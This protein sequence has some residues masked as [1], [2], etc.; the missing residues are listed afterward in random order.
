M[1]EALQVRFCSAL[2]SLGAPAEFG[3]VQWARDEGRHGG[4]HR[5]TA[6]DTSVFDRASINVSQ[7]HYDDLPAKKLSSATALSTIIHPAHPHAPSVHMHLSFTELRDSR[8]GWRLM[9]DLNPSIPHAEDTAAFERA[10]AD[11]AAEHLEAGKAQGDRYF[12]IPAL[13][14]HRGV[15]HF[16]IEGYRTKS[17]AADLEF[18]RRFGAT[19]IDG[20]VEVLRARLE[21]SEVPSEEERM[22][23]LGYHT[24]YFFQ[25]LTLD[26]GTTSGILVHD[27]NDSGILGSLPSHVDRT[28]LERWRSE[29]PQLQRPLMDGL[30]AALP[31]DRIA[32]VDDAVKPALAKVVREHY[33]AF[34]DALALQAS[35]DIVPPTVANHGDA[36]DDR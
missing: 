32:A 2:E 28:L 26:R 15:S 31:D 24:V 17:D 9:A 4:G 27:Q 12:Y 25:V 23:A 36:S 16:Y 14:R 29:L 19:M 22:A 3:R 8:G 11:A 20:Y 18:A 1:V 30:L 6:A 7:V 21:S 35:G 13:K 34:P 33:R 5:R 10:L